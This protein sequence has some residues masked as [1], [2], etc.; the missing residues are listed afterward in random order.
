MFAAVG[1]AGRKHR[2]IAAWQAGWRLAAAAPQQRRAA[3]KCGQRR[4]VS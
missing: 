3:A 4:V 1:P 2:S